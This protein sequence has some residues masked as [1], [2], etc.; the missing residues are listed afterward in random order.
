MLST[1]LKRCAAVCAVAAASS[2]ANVLAVVATSAAETTASSGLRGNARIGSA[3]LRGLLLGCGSALAVSLLR[4]LVPELQPLI[5]ASVIRS[6]RPSLG[7]TPLPQEGPIE[8]APVF[9]SL[10]AGGQSDA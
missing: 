3:K 10:S 1:S 4:S 6:A 8:S 5:E 2:I 7:S 9:L